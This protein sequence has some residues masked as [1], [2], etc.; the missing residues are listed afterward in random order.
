MGVVIEDLIASEMPAAPAFLTHWLDREIV[1]NA[2]DGRFYAVVVEDGGE[3]TSRD[4]DPGAETTAPT[5]VLT[6]VR[7]YGGV[8]R[9]IAAAMTE[10]SPAGEFSDHASTG[11]TLLRS[12][13]GVCAMNDRVGLGDISAV[14]V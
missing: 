5:D 3:V 7:P 2:Q 6:E 14:I 11:R 13:P 10:Q 1:L 12:R 8:R 4:L 9:K